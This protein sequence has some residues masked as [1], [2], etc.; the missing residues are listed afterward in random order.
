[1]PHFFD[2]GHFC[3]WLQIH[4]Q[5]YSASFINLFFVGQ[6]SAVVVSTVAVVGSVWRLHVLPVCMGFLRMLPLPLTDKI[7]S[8]ML[9]LWDVCYIQ[10]KRQLESD[11]F[12]FLFY[13]AEP[14]TPPYPY[15][16]GLIIIR[17]GT[18]CYFST[19]QFQ[20]EVN[21]NKGYN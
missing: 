5:L 16:S 6:H 7:M 9:N 14:T 15:C 11:I 19:V 20:M 18:C 2:T 4:Y 13:R 3:S 1:M 8:E 17:E 12:Y 10:Q 21:L